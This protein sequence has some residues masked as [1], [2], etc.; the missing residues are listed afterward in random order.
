MK[1][2]Q[3]NIGDKFGKWTVTS[4]GFKKPN[5]HQIYYSVICECGKISA[6]IGT[7]LNRG[8]TTGC[9][10]CANTKHGMINTAVYKT[11]ADMKNRCYNPNVSEYPNYGGRGIKVCERWHKFENFYADMKDKPINRTLD[12]INNNGN[13]EPGNCRWSTNSE[14]QQNRR[15]TRLTKEMVYN[16]RVLKKQFPNLS[17]PELA[18]KANCSSSTVR[19]A[20]IG[21]TWKN[22]PKP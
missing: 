22:V 20:V 5:R 17:W 8:K 12:R 21:K 7:V 18:R 15:V 14:Q 16:L 11:W 9:Y 3:I 4:K 2:L 1:K 6:Q 19:S 13:Y 10:S